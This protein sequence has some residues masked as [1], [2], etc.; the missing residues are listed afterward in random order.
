[1]IPITRS[2][3]DTLHGR[4]MTRY[5]VAARL[6]TRSQHDMWSLHGR[7]T[8]CGSYTVAAR[9]VVVTRSQHE[10]L[11]PEFLPT[12][13]NYGAAN[14]LFNYNSLKKTLLF[15]SYAAV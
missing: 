2:Q 4:S 13:M 8:T 14:P 6:V 15:T 11:L 7:S 1:M 12:T 5:K 9:H 3:H 10:T